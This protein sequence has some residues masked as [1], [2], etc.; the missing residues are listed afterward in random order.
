[1]D[2]LAI[3]VYLARLNGM[4]QVLQQMGSKEKS[5]HISLT[6]ANDFNKIHEEIQSH[7]SKVKDL[8]PSKIPTNGNF[9]MLGKAD[10]TFVD[11]EMA[12]NQLNMILETL[13]QHA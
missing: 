9:T 12:C 5:Q 11:F 1:M 7:F 2:D 10:V 13:S 4:T 3:K 8:L 6:T